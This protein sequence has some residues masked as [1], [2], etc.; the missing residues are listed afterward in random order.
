MSRE[1]LAN[2]RKIAVTTAAMVEA[3]LKQEIPCT[4]NLAR[5]RFIKTYC[6]GER[7]MTTSAKEY[8][9]QHGQPSVDDMLPSAQMM[10]RSLKA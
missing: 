9:R 6:S 3:L 10:P 8:R 5:R 2:C 1:L 4:L 7:W